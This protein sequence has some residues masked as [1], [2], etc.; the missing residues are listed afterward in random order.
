MG[1]FRL[2]SCYSSWSKI[3]YLLNKLC[4]LKQIRPKP[5]YTQPKPAK[6]VLGSCQGSRIVSNFA[7]TTNHLETQCQHFQ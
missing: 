4:K 7:A 3:T 2:N 5:I 1:Q 6:S